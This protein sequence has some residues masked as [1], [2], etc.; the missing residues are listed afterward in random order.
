MPPSIL[1]SYSFLGAAFYSKRHSFNG[2]KISSR[3]EEILNTCLHQHSLS[4]KYSFTMSSVKFLPLKAVS[5]LRAPSA[6][7]SYASTTINPCSCRTKY[8]ADKQGRKR[9]ICTSWAAYAKQVNYFSR[10][11]LCIRVSELLKKLKSFYNRI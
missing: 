6:L 7:P 2:A 1:K 4:W 3:Y 10:Q 5:S 8:C 9:G 11:V